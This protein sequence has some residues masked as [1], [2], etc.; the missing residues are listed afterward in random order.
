MTLAWR[1]IGHERASPGVQARVGWADGAYLPHRLR[2][3]LSVYEAGGAQSADGHKAV[4][5][6]CTDATNFRFTVDS[7]GSVQTIGTKNACTSTRALPATVT[8][9]RCGAASPEIEPGISPDT[10]HASAAMTTVVGLYRI[11]DCSFLSGRLGDLLGDV[12]SQAHCAD[13]PP[14]R[15][16]QTSGPPEP[17]E[18]PMPLTASASRTSTTAP[19]A[20]CNSRR[21]RQRL[22]TATLSQAWL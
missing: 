22:A 1:L 19:C 3:L 16:H 13:P 15:P 11:H 18:P 8:Q 20:A 6:Q 7:D 9:L 21:P 5:Y 12:G 2:F 17:P 10:V 14:Q 4:V